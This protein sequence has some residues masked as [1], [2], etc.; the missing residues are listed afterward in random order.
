[1]KSFVW[2]IDFVFVEH[3][4][5]V[6][7]QLVGKIWEFI[8]NGT[9]KWVLVQCHLN[10]SVYLSVDFF[11]TFQLSLVNFDR[12]PFYIRIYDLVSSEPG[13]LIKW[14]IWRVG[15]KQHTANDCDLLFLCHIIR[16][17]IQSA[18]IVRIVSAWSRLDDSTTPRSYVLHN[19]PI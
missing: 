7:S 16:L 12:S 8:G 9:F 3:F 18:N 17:V 19:I 1:M 6:T 11:S 5:F 13:F 2:T 15:D 10:I 14:C 4:G